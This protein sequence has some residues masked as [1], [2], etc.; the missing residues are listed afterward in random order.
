M[1][2][3]GSRS[4]LRRPSPVHPASGCEDLAE[5]ARELAPLRIAAAAPHA[6]RETLQ[7]LQGVEFRLQLHDG[8]GRGRLIQEAPLGV[9]DLLF[10]RV[11]EIRDVIGVELRSRE[12]KGRGVL[13]AALEHVELAQAAL[14]PLAPAAQRLVD[15]LGRRGRAAA[16]GS[17]ARSRPCPPAWRWPARPPD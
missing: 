15:R 16:G 7:P 11:V 13:V 5:Q 14:Q 8:A 3:A 6:E 1:K 9:F 4:C 2:L 10:R 17:S 12:R